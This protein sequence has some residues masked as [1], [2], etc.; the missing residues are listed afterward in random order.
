MEEQSQAKIT[1]VELVRKAAKEKGLLKQKELAHAAGIA[2]SVVSR[3]LSTKEPIVNVKIDNLESLLRTV[4]IWDT[5]T[6]SEGRKAKKVNECNLSLIEKEHVDLIPEFINKHLAKRINQK[7]LGIERSDPD[8][9]YTAEKQIDLL[10]ETLGIIESS[11]DDQE[12]AGLSGRR[13]LVKS[14]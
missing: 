6:K 14:K 8:K 4:G 13:A 5:L 7:L 10:M 11:K 1:L 3:F 12:K 9:L 2:E